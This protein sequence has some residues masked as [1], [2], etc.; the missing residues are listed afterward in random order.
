MEL[1]WVACCLTTQ[2]FFFDVTVKDTCAGGKQKP[3]PSQAIKKSAWT[4]SRDIAVLLKLFNPARC[5]SLNSKC[6]VIGISIP[7][8]I[9]AVD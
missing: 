3:D 9:A 4:L 6:F 7:V 1:S 8:V 2:H 5:V